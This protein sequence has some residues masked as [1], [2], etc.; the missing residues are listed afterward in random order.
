[1]E[2]SEEDSFPPSVFETDYDSEYFSEEYSYETKELPSEIDITRTKVQEDF[3]AEA[4]WEVS[5]IDTRTNTTSEKFMRSV[6]RDIRDQI[7][8]DS[9]NTLDEDISDYDVPAFMTKKKSKA[10]PRSSL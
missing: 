9:E 10:R 3:L 2:Y 5:V 6:E 8:Q 4:E 7:E 1:M